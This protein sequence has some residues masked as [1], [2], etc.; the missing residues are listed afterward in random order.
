VSDQD[1]R[2]TIKPRLDVGVDSLVCIARAPKVY[3]LDVGR[4]RADGSGVQRQVP[5]VHAY[6]PGE[7]RQK[8]L[9]QK[10]VLG[11]EIAMD[12]GAFV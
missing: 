12:D 9:A 5:S 1:L 3:E 2:R 4:S 6:H 11:L 10:D 8:V 7:R